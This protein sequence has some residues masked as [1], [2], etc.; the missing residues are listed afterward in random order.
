[1][2]REMAE[3]WLE[4]AL[5]GSWSR[6]KQPRIPVSVREIVAEG[7]ACAGEGA[8]TSTGCEPDAARSSAP[9]GISRQPPRCV[10]R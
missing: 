10:P 9:A 2:L 8:A 6:A 5:N 4:V 1:M 3:T 7:I